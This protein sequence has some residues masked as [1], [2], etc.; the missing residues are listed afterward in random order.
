MHQVQKE[1]IISKYRKSI[2]QSSQSIKVKDNSLRN[3]GIVGG[4]VATDQL[5]GGQELQQASMIM[6]EA[7]KPVSD[8]VF[9]GLL[10]Q[11]R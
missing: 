10:R 4:K 11:K 8:L 1:G 9:R 5:E 2:K 6:Y 3:A 7:S